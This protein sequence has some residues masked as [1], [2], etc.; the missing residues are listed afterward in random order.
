MRELPPRHP[1]PPPPPPAHHPA[2]HR[3]GPRTSCAASVAL[4]NWL[5]IVPNWNDVPVLPF[6][7]L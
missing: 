7:P 4:R 3:F 6:N 2:S 1:P 5:H